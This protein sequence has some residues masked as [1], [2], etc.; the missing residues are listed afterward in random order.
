MLREDIEALGPGNFQDLDFHEEFSS[1]ITRMGSVLTPHRIIITNDM[2]TWRKRNSVLV[3][4]DSTQVKR[5]SITSVDIVDNVIGCDIVIHAQGH[6]N[7]IATN[8]SGSDAERIR[9]LI[10]NT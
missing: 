10:L 6:P 3:G 2:V 1:R 8:F 4:V 5:A 9:E 7:I